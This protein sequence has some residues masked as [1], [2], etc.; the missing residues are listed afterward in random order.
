MRLGQRRRHRLGRL[1]DLWVIREHEAKIATVLQDLAGLLTWAFTGAG[2]ED[3]TR[4][5]MITN[6]VLYQL[7]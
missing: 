7:S 1:T 6:Q 5:L 2:C 3:R 4:H